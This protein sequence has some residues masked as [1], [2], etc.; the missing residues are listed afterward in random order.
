[1]NFLWYIAF[2]S[3]GIL[4]MIIGVGYRVVNQS[5]VVKKDEKLDFKKFLSIETLSRDEIH[6]GTPT[7]ER[8]LGWKS[9]LGQKLCKNALCRT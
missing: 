7:V 8:N 4:K 5:F 1:M 3:E 2:L 9:I 6:V